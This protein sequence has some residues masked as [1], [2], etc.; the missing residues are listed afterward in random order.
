MDMRNID[1]LLDNFDDEQDIYFDPDMSTLVPEGTYG[2]EVISL[3]TKK[4]NTKKGGS[5]LLYKPKY[6]II[7]ES[8]PSVHNRE[9]DDV[10]IWRFNGVKDKNGKRVTGGSNINYKRYLE[11]FNIPMTELEY[12]GKIV[13]RLPHIDSTAIKGKKVIISVSHDEWQGKYGRN[14][15]ALATLVREMNTENG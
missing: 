14:V 12:E 15:T 8:K 13:Y 5:G 7:A 11:K 9:V 10:G 1:D 3:Y 2:A 4:I 6:Q